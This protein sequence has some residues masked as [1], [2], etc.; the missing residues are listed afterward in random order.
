MIG[1]AVLPLREIKGLN[2]FSTCVLGR[3]LFMNEQ[4]WT[5]LR[6]LSQRSNDELARDFVMLKFDR[7]HDD[8][9]A[10]MQTK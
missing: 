10:D 9:L 7:R 8:E 4:G 1:V 2:T 6:I 3:S 5:I